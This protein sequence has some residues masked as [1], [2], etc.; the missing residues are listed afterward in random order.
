MPLQRGAGDELRPPATAI[1]GDGISMR[2]RLSEQMATRATGGEIPRHRLAGI[3]LPRRLG[4]AG[5]LEELDAGTVRV[6]L[7]S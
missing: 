5:V 4:S 1:P 3:Q 6:V 2:R 7:P